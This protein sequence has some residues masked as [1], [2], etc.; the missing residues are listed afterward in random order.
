MEIREFSTRAEAKELTFGS[1]K[2]T[3]MKPGIHGSSP[4]VAV[5]ITESEIDPLGVAQ[6][7]GG[8]AILCSG[9]CESLPVVIF[10]LSPI[11]VC[12]NPPTQW[13]RVPAKEVQYSDPFLPPRSHPQEVLGP[14]G[15]LKG[16]GPDF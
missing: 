3:H 9:R 8:V 4:H 13:V 12:G 2:V 11:L 5:L 16:K 14:S 15:Q 6:G 1:M 7:D 10:T